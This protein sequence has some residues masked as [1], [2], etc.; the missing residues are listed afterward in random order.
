MEQDQM[1]RRGKETNS[2]LLIGNKQETSNAV[3]YTF[4]ILAIRGLPHR[5]SISSE[6][7]RDLRPV[8]AGRDDAVEEYK[9]E[10]E[11]GGGRKDQVR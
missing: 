7:Q 5:I 6:I 11:A 9:M 4:V 2:R 10:E 8:A 1:E 3:A